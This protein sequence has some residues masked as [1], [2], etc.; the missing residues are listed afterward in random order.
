MGCGRLSV[1]NQRQYSGATSNW[2]YCNSP[3]ELDHNDLSCVC[4]PLTPRQSNLELRKQMETTIPENLQDQSIRVARTISEVEEL[5]PH[6]KSLAG[7]RESD[8]DY[9]LA[10]LTA[11][12]ESVRPHVLSVWNDG[13][14]TGFLVGR[15]DKGP[16]VFRGSHLRFSTIATQMHFLYGALR[17]EVSGQ[18]SKEIVQNI[19][20]SLA[21]GE[22]DVANLNFLR[23]DSELYRYAKELPSFLFR[24]HLE[25]S[26]RHYTAQLPESLAEF[27]RDL[28]PKLRKN[29]RWKK[30]VR[31]FPDAVRIECYKDPS[32]V[33]RLATVADRIASLSYQRR[34]GVGFVDDA[35][36]RGRLQLK[37]ANSW[38]RGYVLYLAD[39]PVAF[40]IGDLG[41][42]VFGSD[43]LAFDPAFSKYSP[44]MYLIVRVIENICGCQANRGVI[45]DFGTGHAEY[46]E[47]LST[48]VWTEKCVYIFSPSLKG[49]SL[50][51]N[52]TVTGGAEKAIRWTLERAGLLQ[53]I[54]KVWR[55]KSAPAT[56]PS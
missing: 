25:A 29:Q 49:L 46:K 45:V 13:R 53:R 3:I 30:L 28:S 47:M 44:G 1:F 12:P 22:A 52:K 50:N 40:W 7:P 34:I 21:S 17:G 8:I 20:K 10:V 16:V 9:F 36:T 4:M 39:Q 35:D 43:Y 11:K 2:A 56:S 27:Q 14:P 18:Q 37:A 54:K 48:H 41:A 55:S 42:S 51:L 6:W 26:Q 23:A 24:D 32:D 15:I 19:C 38:L 5:R 33:D 31:D